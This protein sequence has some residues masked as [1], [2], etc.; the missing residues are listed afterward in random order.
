MLEIN[1]PDIQPDPETY[2]QQRLQQ[3]PQTR[4]R[5]DDYYR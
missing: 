5:C 2:K 4:G 3:I 1:P